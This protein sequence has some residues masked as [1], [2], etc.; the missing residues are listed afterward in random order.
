[1]TDMQRRR[2]LDTYGVLHKRAVDKMAIRFSILTPSGVL[3]LGTYDGNSIKDLYSEM[4]CIMFT[5]V[6]TI[7]NEQR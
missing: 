7:E 2:I 3:F 4:Q 6:V 1:M 5:T